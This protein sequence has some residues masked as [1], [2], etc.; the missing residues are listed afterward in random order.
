MDQMIPL[1]DSTD[2]MRWAEEFA[3]RVREGMDAADEG[4]LVTWFAGAIEVGK[5][6]GAQQH[7]DRLHVDLG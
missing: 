7:C 2:A 4:H 3:H 1:Q 5:R 6:H